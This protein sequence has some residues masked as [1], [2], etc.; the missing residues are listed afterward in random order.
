M[1]HVKHIKKKPKK[2][3]L[4]PEQVAESVRDQLGPMLSAI[5]GGV[6]AKNSEFLDRI[7]R[8]AA[9][10]AIWGTKTNLTANP[11]DPDEILF[12]VFDSIIPLSIVVSSKILRL[13]GFDRER[14]FLDVGSGA[15][16]PGLVIASA[17]NA[18]VTLV[19]PRRKR[20]S[21]LSDAVVEM[22]LRN[23]R[24][25]TARAESLDVGDG[26]DLITARGVGIPL[27]MIKLAGRGLHPG[28]VLMLYVSAAQKFDD[29]VDA[30][31]AAG[32]GEVSISG[33]DLR[34]GKQVVNRAVATWVRR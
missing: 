34:H 5:G 9:T 6:I 23:V 7:E 20:A 21:F 8:L 27:E 4:N 15:G 25:E 18:Q 30:A 2:K 3:A 33:Y 13:G 19:E 32:L 11:R 26:F 14:R 17:I 12:H 1:F 24:V 31:R 22:G 28:G 29:V 10:L 16:F